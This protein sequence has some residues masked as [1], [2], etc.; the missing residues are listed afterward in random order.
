ML[1]QPAFLDETAARY[2]IGMW[3]CHCIRDTE[4]TR[5][6][7]FGLMEMIPICLT[8]PLISQER[9]RR[10]RDELLPMG[11]EALLQDCQES[12]HQLAEVAEHIR[13]I[14]SAAFKKFRSYRYG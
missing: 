14:Q 10:R 4:E 3:R 1:P 12:L 13:A 2:A 9:S 8:V 6:L 11:S 7:V 5:P